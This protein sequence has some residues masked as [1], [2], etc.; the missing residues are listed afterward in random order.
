[1]TFQNPVCLLN[2]FARRMSGDQVDVTIKWIQA[3][4]ELV[5]KAQV[6]AHPINTGRMKQEL[7]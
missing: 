4:Q 5:W 6:G 7:G 1:M 3:K 2:S